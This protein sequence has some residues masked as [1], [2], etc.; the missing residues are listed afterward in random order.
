[1]ET[2]LYY[3][4]P[5]N[6]IFEEVRTKAIELWNT[7]DNTYEYATSKIAMIDKIENVKDNLMF[8]IAMFDI[9]NQSRLARSLSQDARDAI[10]ARL[11]TTENPEYIVDIWR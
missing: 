8:M 6:V 1:M 2:N 7:Y 3:I 9:N 11:I 5:N 4:A 10:R